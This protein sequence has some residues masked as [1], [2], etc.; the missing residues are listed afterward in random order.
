MPTLRELSIEYAKKQPTQVNT[1]LEETPILDI[2][3]FEAASHGLWNVHEEIESITGAGFVEMDQVLPTLAMTSKLIHV[4][5]SIMGGKIYCGEDKAKMFGGK[6]KYF[7]HK[8]PAILGQT[9][10]DTEV[11][12]LYNCIRKY[13]IANSLITKA[14][15]SSD[16]NYTILFVRF[17]E[18]VT[19]GLYSP[20][21]FKQ[22]A[23]LD[24]KP[25][26]G[27]NMFEHY[28]T[29]VL[30]YG[31]RLKGYF[32]FRMADT[33]TVHAIVNFDASN[34]PTAIQINNAITAVRGNPGNTKIFMHQKA[35]DLLY[36]F[37]EDDLQTRPMDRDYN[38]TYD[39][40]GRIPIIT[41]YNFLDATEADV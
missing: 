13:C 6:E 15:G 9:G 30:S 3:P 38:L 26:N 16:A 35:L 18:G 27:G 17:K 2:I 10:V 32:G 8:M 41:S 34:L 12:I 29:G 28:S 19:G 22:G 23:M 31:L 40:W 37:K 21:G 4:D 5:L 1:L 36:K 33:K 7:A 39:H 20:E 24:T 11:A 14:A 25:I